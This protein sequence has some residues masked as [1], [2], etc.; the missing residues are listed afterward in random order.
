[1]TGTFNYRAVVS[2]LPGYLLF[3]YSAAR[4][5]HVTS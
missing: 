3:G 4:S 1:M 5:L 2:D